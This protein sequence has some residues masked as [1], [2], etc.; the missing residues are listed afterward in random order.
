MKEKTVEKETVRKNLEDRISELD[1]QI[2]VMEIQLKNTPLSL[3]GI[4]ERT[5]I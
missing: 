3:N 2:E 5:K 1:S 4:T